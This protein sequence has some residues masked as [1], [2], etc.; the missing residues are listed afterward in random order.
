MRPQIAPEPKPSGEWML[1][2]IPFLAL[3]EM[4][5]TGWSASAMV[6]YHGG[7][8]LAAAQG[9]PAGHATFT[10]YASVCHLTRA[11]PAHSAAMVPLCPRGSWRPPRRSRVV[12]WTHA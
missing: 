11:F 10:T 5:T 9:V 8:E 12:K 6:G 7:D 4:H 2:P 1:G 3:R